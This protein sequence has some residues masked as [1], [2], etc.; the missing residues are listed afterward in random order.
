MSA[1]HG[2]PA[3]PAPTGHAARSTGA[4]DRRLRDARAARGCEC[5]AGAGDRH[6]H[7]RHQRQRGRPLRRPRLPRADQHRQRDVVHQPQ[8]PQLRRAPTP[9][10][11]AT[12]SPVRDSDGRHDP[13]PHRAVRRRRDL[14]E[15]ARRRRPR[16]VPARC[17]GPCATLSINRPS[18]D[19]YGLD[20]S[21][22]VRTG[23]FTGVDSATGGDPTGTAGATATCVTGTEGGARPCASRSPSARRSPRPSRLRRRPTRTTGCA[24]PPTARC[25]RR[26]PRRPQATRSASPT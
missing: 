20:L 19:F 23:A 9:R 21:L 12:P 8:R 5:G 17:S 18:V 22:N 4:D 26:S 13:D 7:E 2:R 24:R 15:R 10:R 3:Q 16:R 14:R 1:R 6:H 25:A 11:G